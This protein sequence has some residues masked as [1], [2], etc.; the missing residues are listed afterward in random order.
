MAIFSTIWRIWSTCSWLCKK[1]S[2]SMQMPKRTVYSMFSVAKTYGIFVHFCTNGIAGLH[3]QKCHSVINFV[4]KSWLTD[5]WALQVFSVQRDKMHSLQIPAH[6]SFRSTC[7]VWKTVHCISKCSSFW[8]QDVL[9]CGW[10]QN[11]FQSEAKIETFQCPCL[12]FDL[13]L[14]HIAYWQNIYFICDSKGSSES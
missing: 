7:S 5:F 4:H 8:N 10:I 11:I 1:V 14:L 6:I 3:L 9:I 12:E 13:C 2:K